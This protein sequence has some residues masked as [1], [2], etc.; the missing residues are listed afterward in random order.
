MKVFISWSGPLSHRI[1]LILRDWLP[2]V[3]PCMDPWVSSEDI[4]K[5]TR[6]G[7]ELARELE[8]THSGIICL[9]PDNLAEP[10]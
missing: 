1:A 8:G 4:P 5:G 2:V 10:G 9:V 6:W 3:L 7:T